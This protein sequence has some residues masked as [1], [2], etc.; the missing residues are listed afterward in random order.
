MATD[1]RKLC[2]ELFGTDDVALLREI[3]EKTN[4]KNPRN[5]G[6][7]KRFSAAEITDMER[8][9]SEGVT[10]NEIAQRYHTSRQVI[11]RYLSSK[12]HEGCT[13][14]MTYMFHQHPCTVIDLDF[15]NR[16][17]FIENKTNDLLHRAF[18]INEHPNWEDFEAFLQDR[19][20]PKSRG[21]CRQILHEMG[22]TDYD[23]LQI[24]EKTQGRIAEDNLWIRFQYYPKEVAT[25]EPH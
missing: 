23:P 10:V 14:R 25:H 17:V 19:C 2:V 1:Y 20:F 3:A 5:A 8:L 12:P 21:N 7:K 16:R 18:G 11:G 22:L 9:R 4:Q 13:L 15:L 24:V 6:R